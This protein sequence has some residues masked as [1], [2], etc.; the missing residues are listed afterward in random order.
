MS[1]NSDVC[2]K[3]GRVLLT[4]REINNKKCGSCLCYEYMSHED[5][6]GE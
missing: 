3:C 6:Y 2:L 5:L 4:E 1:K